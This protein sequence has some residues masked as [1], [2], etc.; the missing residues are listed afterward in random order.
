[1]LVRVKE[2]LLE[3]GVRGLDQEGLVVSLMKINHGK[4]KCSCYANNSLTMVFVVKLC[5]YKW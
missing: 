2:R 4:H 5:L 3:E 1:M